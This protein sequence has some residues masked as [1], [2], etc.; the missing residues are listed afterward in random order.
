VRPFGDQ[1][2]PGGLR[3]VISRDF[4]R[5]LV[6]AQAV[7]FGQAGGTPV[8]LRPSG[9]V[10]PGDATVFRGGKVHLIERL[11]FHRAQEE[12]LG[13]DALAE[14]VWGLKTRQ[15]DDSAFWVL[16][17]AQRRVALALAAAFAVAI[18]VAPTV[19]LAVFVLALS[20]MN[21]AVAAFRL[22]L[23]WFAPE[24]DF[25][26]SALRLDAGSWSEL[27]RYTVMVPMYREAG[28]VPVLVRAIG[29]LAYPRDRLEIFLVCESDDAATLAA[30]TRAAE[31]DGRFRVIAVPACEPRTKPKALNYAL[32]FAQG[33]L[34][35][36]YDAEDRPERDQLLKA[37][38]AFAEGSADLACV[39]ARLNWYNRDRNWLTRS[40]AL[41]YALWFDYMLPGLQR[42]GAPIPLGGT[43]NH[44]KTSAL[45]A[46][47]G[48]DPF[49]VTED[50]D[51]GLRFMRHGA[52]V[53]TLNS[54]TLEEATCTA[55]AWVRQ[56]SRWIKG[57]M[58][59]WL[60]Q[61][62]DPARLWR[63]AGPLGFVSFQLFV[64]GVAATALGNPILWALSAI[65]FAFAAFGMDP[66]VPGF[67]VW[68]ATAA[69]LAGNFCLIYLNMLCAL[70]RRWLDLVPAALLTPAYWVLIS[71]AGYKALGQLIVKPFYWEKTDHGVAGAG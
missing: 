39:Q 47:G 23:A 12:V 62:R 70:R 22:G 43:S 1:R 31:D 69:L 3:R 34:L 26:P 64:G 16:T 49:N 60:V 2:G 29:G 14:A 6:A 7:P 48:W 30:A 18:A 8:V 15:P 42:T 54:T 24:P 9:V 28:V 10:E 56:R 50:A 44:F 37:A 71:I 63:T 20:A 57:Y 46:C 38:R 52:V 36:I 19:A 59:T 55:P 45:I 41:E 27:P 13:P 53:G 66:P 33:E 21:F 35:V 4:V 32:S 61:M 17:A 51:L 40:F 25:E 11:E 67:G 68:W 5:A 58:Q 65:G